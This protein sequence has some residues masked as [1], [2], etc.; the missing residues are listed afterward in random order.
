MTEDIDDDIPE[1]ASATIPSTRQQLYLR[2]FTAILID[3]TV[4]NLFDEY[5]NLVTLDSFTISM[6]AAILL[7]VL[8]KL[9]LA[10]E[11]RIAH[12]FHGK[13]GIG[14]RLL[15]G[16]SAWLVLFGSKFAMLAAINVAFGPDV[17]LG[18]PYHGVVAFIVLVVTMLVA[19]EL[20][21]RFY[22]RLS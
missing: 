8:L 14:A 21:V 11:H 15:R 22:R 9:T 4:L 12:F 20:I 19:E 1:V 10:I 5:W 6:L 3:L 16:L 17:V 7:Q 13:P 18:G 2:Y